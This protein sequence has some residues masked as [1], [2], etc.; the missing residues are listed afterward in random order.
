[1]VDAC[2][3]PFQE[4]LPNANFLKHIGNLYVG[5]SIYFNIQ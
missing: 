4:V 2:R 3:F 1:M 5:P